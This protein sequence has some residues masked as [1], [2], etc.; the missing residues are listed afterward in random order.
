M[1]EGPVPLLEDLKFFIGGEEVYEEWK[2]AKL[3]NVAVT[4]EGRYYPGKL[5]APRGFYLGP[6]IRFAHYQG[7]L[8]EY[9]YQLTGPEG[10]EVR[11]T[12]PVSGKLNKIT[13]GVLTGVQWKLGEK[14]Y[15]DW[16]LVGIAAGPAG[17]KLRGKISLSPEEQEAVRR[18]LEDLDFRRMKTDVEVDDNG[19]RADISGTFIDLRAGICLGFRF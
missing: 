4:A 3:S 12:I 18:E 15:L 7:N 2:N 11:K 19:T 5:G 16:W 1:P 13:A 10:E 9:E 6:Y 14:L 17:G 8:P